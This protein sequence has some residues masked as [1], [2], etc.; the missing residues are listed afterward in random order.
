MHER[1]QAAQ[2]PAP[3]MSMVDAT[4]SRLLAL[5]A[6][7]RLFTIPAMLLLITCKAISVVGEAGQRAAGHWQP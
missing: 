3:T 7:S 4:F 5:R 6:E 1:L 2:S